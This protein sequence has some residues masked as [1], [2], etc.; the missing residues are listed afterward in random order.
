MD[1][2]QRPKEFFEEFFPQ[3]FEL[4]RRA[5]GA[6]ERSSAVTFRIE[7]EGAWT[8]QVCDARLV[9]EAEPCADARLQLAFNRSDFEAIA[10][11]RARREMSERGSISP[12]SLGPFR[13]LFSL[14]S[15]LDWADREAGNSLLFAIEDGG[16]RRKMHI[17]PGA[18][19]LPDRARAV[20]HLGLKE[21]LALLNR[22]S[23]AVTMMLLR[24][25]RVSGD[26][27]F[28]LRA[29]HLLG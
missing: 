8:I 11:R 5:L 4:H 23:S 26:L 27:G 3:Q 28:A 15:K 29:N 7:E 22:E 13:L 20:I 25:L 9:V 14:E 24:R 18:G 1:V 10:I 21:F 12:R 6:G 17:V 19:P 16:V 2:P